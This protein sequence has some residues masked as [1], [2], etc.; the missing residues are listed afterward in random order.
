MAHLSSVGMAISGGECKWLSYGGHGTRQHMSLQQPD[1]HACVQVVTAWNGLAIGA[2]AKA[3]RVLTSEPD[4]VPRKLF[5]VIGRLAKEY[6]HGESGSV[7]M[8]QLCETASA[9]FGTICSAGQVSHVCLPELSPSDTCA[10][11]D[12]RGI[13]FMWTGFQTTSRIKFNQACQIYLGW[14]H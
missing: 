2:L 5:P 6:L 12:V 1:V 10:C 8:L 14:H 11:A 9:G 3:S 4:E 7:L 13:L